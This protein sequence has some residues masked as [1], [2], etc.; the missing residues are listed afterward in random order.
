MP[1]QVLANAICYNTSTYPSFHK[2]LPDPRTWPSQQR[3]NGVGQAGLLIVCR[4][5]LFPHISACGLFK[6]NLVQQDCTT[7]W[8]DT[9]RERGGRERLPVNCSSFQ[10]TAPGARPRFLGFSADEAPASSPVLVSLGPPGVADAAA[11][12]F[13][14]PLGVSGG[15]CATAFAAFR[16][17]I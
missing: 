3:T 2:R 16:G 15:R 1:S 10:F 8:L 12:G 4:S 17:G 5:D 14:G 13:G 9:R 11:A 7:Q 6:F